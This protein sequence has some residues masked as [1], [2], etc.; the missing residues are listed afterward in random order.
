VNGTGV[1]LGVWL[2]L[3]SPLANAETTK[4]PLEEPYIHITNWELHWSLG[5]VVQTD[6]DSYYSFPILAQYPVK[7]CQN[8]R[9][10]GNEVYL[11]SEGIRYVISSTPMLYLKPPNDWVMYGQEV[12]NRKD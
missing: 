1:L 8:I 7:E 5:I 4:K 2:L 9:K 11:M 3:S 10:V 12:K 6:T